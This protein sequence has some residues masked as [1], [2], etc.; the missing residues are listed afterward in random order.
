MLT[1]W[2][3]YL[4]FVIFRWIVPN[5]K[6]HK[7]QY[8]Y[9]SSVNLLEGTN[10][11]DAFAKRTVS[12]Q[13]SAPL[14]SSQVTEGREPKKRSNSIDDPS[15]GVKLIASE[16]DSLY[17]QRADGKVERR[18]DKTDHEKSDIDRSLELLDELVVELSEKQPQGTPLE[19]PSLSR[20]VDGKSTGSASDV[21]VSPSPSQ[22]SINSEKSTSGSELIH[23]DVPISPLS[24]T[25]PS[26]YHSDPTPRTPKDYTFIQETITETDIKARNSNSEPAI[27]GKL[28]EEAA[29]LVKAKAAEKEQNGEHKT[30]I[31][32]TASSPADLQAVAPQ[33]T[34]KLRRRESEKSRRRQAAKAQNE[35]NAKES[36]AQQKKLEDGTTG[37][38]DEQQNAQ[39][40]GDIVAS[41]NKGSQA[42]LAGTEHRTWP[43]TSVET[44][45]KE[46]GKKKKAT[47]S[48]S[49]KLG[50]FLKKF[51]HSNRG[52][53]CR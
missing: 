24:E 1:V 14:L 10:K 9:L 21:V 36:G 41:G 47:K 40:S 26:R 25:Y 18:H 13:E 4:P 23:K 31:E 30:A 53:S 6:L 22:T 51:Y 35:A 19:R 11:D 8:T 37:T 16:A 5:C 46:P 38:Q 3:L 42:I 27:S 29:D 32:R 17:M 34:Q 2:K 33:P 15:S 12:K 7:L 43:R 49:T 28:L 44:E 45:P 52:V 39:G 20:N 48:V 50:V